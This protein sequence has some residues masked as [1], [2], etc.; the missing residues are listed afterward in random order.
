MEANHARE[1]AGDLA[2]VIVLLAAI[3]AHL[4]VVLGVAHVTDPYLDTLGLLGLAYLGLS[5]AT[6]K[7]A[8]GGA[9]IAVETRR[10]ADV[11]TERLD[12][13]EDTK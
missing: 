3:L 5:G 6:A 2:A 11:S 9:A 13:M 4:L 1:I 8:N 7:T 10:R 12:A